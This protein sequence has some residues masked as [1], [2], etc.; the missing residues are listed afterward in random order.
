MATMTPAELDD[1]RRRCEQRLMAL[2][3]VVGVG[4]G[5]QGGKPVLEVLVDR[6]APEAELAPE[7]AIPE[8]IDG[9]GVHVREVGV[10][11]AER[12]GDSG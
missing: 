2:P 4:V 7:E 1:V 3:N 5:E 9:F 6:K 8:A 11:I 12:S 10:P